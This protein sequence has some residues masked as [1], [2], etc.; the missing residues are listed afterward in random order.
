M[1]YSSIHLLWSMPWLR[2][3]NPEEHLDSLITALFT[4]IYAL[5]WMLYVP[6]LTLWLKCTS[7][8]KQRRSKNQNIAQAIVD[9]DGF[10][11]VT[12]GG[13]YGKTLGGGVAVARKWVQRSGQAARNRGNKKGKRRRRRSML[14]KRQRNNDLVCIFLSNLNSPCY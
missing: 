7:T 5:R 8:N 3:A 12:R 14:S 10:T 2:R 1:L 13:A 9:A 11:L 4:I 6:L